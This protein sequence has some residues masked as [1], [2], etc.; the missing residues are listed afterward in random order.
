[1]RNDIKTFLKN[2]RNNNAK[3]ALSNL[4]TIIDKKEVIRKADVSTT[5]AEE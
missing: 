3:Q 1:M 4:K 2:I 5:P